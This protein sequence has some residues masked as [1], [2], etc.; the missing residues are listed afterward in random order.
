MTGRAIK[1]ARPPN[2][3]QPPGSYLIRL[4]NIDL[5]SGI[6]LVRLK[7]PLARQVARVAITH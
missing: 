1:L 5:P 7:T 4:D 2:G 6:Y 3:Y